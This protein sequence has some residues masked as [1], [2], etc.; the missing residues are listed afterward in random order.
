MYLKFK[1]TI[2]ISKSIYP[3]PTRLQGKYSRIKLQNTFSRL[4][5]LHK[6]IDYKFSSKPEFGPKSQK[7]KFIL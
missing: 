5:I 1:I 3:L 7:V 2:Y 6:I 4:F